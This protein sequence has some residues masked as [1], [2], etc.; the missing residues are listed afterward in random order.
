MK[1]SILKYLPIA[2]ALSYATSCSN[3][4]NIIL[5]QP[6]LE[7]DV[8]QPDF[9][10]VPFSISVD[11]EH[12]TLSKILS[13]ENEDANRKQM[14]FSFEDDDINQ[15]HYVVLITE[16]EE[17]EYLSEKYQYLTLSKNANGDFVFTGE[18]SV[19]ASKIDEF[20]SGNCWLTADL[21]GKELFDYYKNANVKYENI[22]EDWLSGS[23]LDE[24]LQLSGDFKSNA[25]RFSLSSPSYVYFNIEVEDSNNQDV[26]VS[27][28]ND[29]GST[30]SKLLNLRT[31]S[32]FAYK[33]R[34][35]DVFKCSDLKIDPIDFEE[36]INYKIFR[37][38]K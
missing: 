30:V 25:D 24:V 21:M 6:I 23:S 28:E 35:G 2:A 18:L 11:T 5:S 7:E 17:D 19:K 9:V 20:N 37:I 27:I 31:T 38:I 15:Y 13:Q 1:K 26:N 14:T 16:W 34:I 8:A 33:V 36:N 29:Y 4:E 3:D 12:K 22:F 10:K 32:W